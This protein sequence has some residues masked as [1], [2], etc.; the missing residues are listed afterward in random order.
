M[1]LTR[2]G[3]ICLTLHLMSNKFFLFVGCFF[4]F[5]L[6]IFRIVL[7]SY[8]K[9]ERKKL[10]SMLKK[11]IFGTFLYGK[12]ILHC[13]AVVYFYS[14]WNGNAWFC[15]SSII[16][17]LYISCIAFLLKNLKCWKL[18]SFSSPNILYLMNFLS[19]ILINRS[20]FW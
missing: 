10:Y 4:F 16:I 20:F 9:K 18:N 15:L 8:K 5:Y 2:Y 13:H 14:K 17:L 3:F 19:K 7:T 11:K 12:I 6:F 1:T